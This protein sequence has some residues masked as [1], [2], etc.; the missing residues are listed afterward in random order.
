MWGREVGRGKW[1]DWEGD[2][3]GKSGK[4][5]EMGGG[6]ERMGCILPVRVLWCCC[7]EGGGEGGKE[8]WMGVWVSGVRT[9]DVL[10]GKQVSQNLLEKSERLV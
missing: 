4:W 10:G 2:G 3:M 9:V 7:E 8:R 1:G 6:N 5:G